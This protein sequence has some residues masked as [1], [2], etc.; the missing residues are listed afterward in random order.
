M[1]V[2]N[3]IQCNNCHD[4]IHSFHRHDFVTCSCGGCSVDGGTVY[5]RR[6][7]SNYTDLSLTDE[8]PHKEIREKMVWGRVYDKNMK[9]LPKV[10][11]ILLKDITDEHLQ[12]LTT[13][14][15]LEGTEIQKIFQA[16]QKYRDD[17]S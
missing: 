8:A 4:V 11:W 6:V 10:E 1:I 14:K 7:G 16:E 2:Y 5:S 17:K 13:Y 9:R 3:A 15:S 12:A